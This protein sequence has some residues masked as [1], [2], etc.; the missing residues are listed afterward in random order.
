MAI[1]SVYAGHSQIKSSL[2]SFAFKFVPKSY[3]KIIR[4]ISPRY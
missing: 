3:Q 4:S 2:Y 1:K